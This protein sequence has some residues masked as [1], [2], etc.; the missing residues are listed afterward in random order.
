MRAALSAV[1]QWLRD[2][3]DLPWRLKG[4]FLGVLGALLVMLIVVGVTGGTAD[5]REEAARLIALSPPAEPTVLTTVETTRVPPPRPVIKTTVVVKEVVPSP[6]VIVREVEVPV[7]DVLDVEQPPAPPPPDTGLYTYSGPYVFTG[8]GDKD[9]V[10]FCVSKSQFTAAW[11]IASDV[12]EYAGISGF[13]YPSGETIS[14][15]AFF[16]YDGA[17][18]DSTI[19]RDGPGCFY[20][21]VITANLLSWEIRVTQ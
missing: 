1:G 19:V 4:P 8:Q 7:Q 3:W 15:S 20:V 21:S 12:P 14:Y 17:G 16:T 13:V 10:D 18:S 6:T 2:A 5:P 9:T 11:T